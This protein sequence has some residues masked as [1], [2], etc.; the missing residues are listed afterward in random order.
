LPPVATA[1]VREWKVTKS[2]ETRNGDHFF[3]LAAIAAAT[4]AVFMVMVWAPMQVRAFDAVW[5][6]PAGRPSWTGVSFV[7]TDG[8]TADVETYSGQVRVVTMLYTHCPGACPLAVSTLQSMESRL[9]AAQRE[10]LSIIAL[11]LDPEHDSVAALQDFAS[12]RHIDARHWVL[13]RPSTDGTRQLA[14]GLGVGY[15]MRGDAT[16]DHQSVFV[17]L[18]RN[19]EVLARSS[20]TR[21]PDPRFFGALQRALAGH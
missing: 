10:R 1:S 16:V 8:K 11:S 15:Q 12:V 2:F 4:A 21:N 9:T 14:E 7:T 20:S 3:L 19:G 5:K 13:G 6:V 18:G 17:L